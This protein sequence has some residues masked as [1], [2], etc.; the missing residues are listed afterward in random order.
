MNEPVAW[1]IKNKNGEWLYYDEE[2]VGTEP[3]YSQAVVA[4]REKLIV[5][6]NGR[7]E[8]M[9]EKQSHYESMEHAAGFEAGREQERALWELAASTQEAYILELENGLKSSINLNKA[10][11]ERSQ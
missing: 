2:L 4:L 5:E 7:I 10:Q 3:L 8:R 9:I 1:R 11:A 6:L